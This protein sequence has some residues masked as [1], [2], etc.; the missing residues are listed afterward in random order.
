[1][2]YEFAKYPDETLVVFS[3]IRYEFAKYPDETLVVFSDIRKKDNGEEYI[4]VSF[5]RPTE[6]G[7]DTVVFELPS[8]EI[9]EQDGNYSEEEIKEFRETVEKGAHLFFKYAREGGLKFA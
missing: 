1:M 5:E 8:Y 9:V 4:R 3:D 2:V 6:N 7:F